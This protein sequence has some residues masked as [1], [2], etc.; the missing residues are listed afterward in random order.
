MRT[1]MPSINIAE[2]NARTLTV[3]L[4]KLATETEDED[5]RHQLRNL[6]VQAE[7]LAKA[8]KEVTWA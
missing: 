6:V 3:Q 2:S 4:R 8:I 7:A 1:L 5:Q